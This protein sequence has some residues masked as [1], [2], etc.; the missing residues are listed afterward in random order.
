MV[1]RDEIEAKNDDLKAVNPNAKNVEDDRTAEQLL[2]II[3]LKSK[4]VHAAIE[5]LR[6]I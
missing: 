3:D 6:K 2:E 1:T 5:A 4:E